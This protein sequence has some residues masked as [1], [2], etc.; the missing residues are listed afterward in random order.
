[1][2]V[3]VGIGR[4]TRSWV[5]LAPG[6][7]CRFRPG[8]P[9]PTPA[10]RHLHQ[11][12]GGQKGGVRRWGLRGRGREGRASSSSARI[13]IRRLPAFRSRAAA[14]FAASSASRRSA[15][16]SWKGLLGLTR[17]SKAGVRA[18]E[19]GEVGLLGLYEV[20]VVVEGPVVVLRP[21]L[22]PLA[23]LLQPPSL[24]PCIGCLGVERKP[25]LRASPG[26]LAGSR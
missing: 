25:S 8:S 7:P 3:K 5:V 17:G 6:D 20:V 26:P 22:L 24:S 13:D 21:L 15:S 1:M 11:G 4:P 16:D 23:V 18:N 10:P 19:G 12:L 2:W 9:S 14:S